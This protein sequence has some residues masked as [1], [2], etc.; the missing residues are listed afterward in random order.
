MFSR[1]QVSAGSFYLAVPRSA[2]GQGSVAR[3]AR[4]YFTGGDEG[5]VVCSNRRLQPPLRRD[6]GV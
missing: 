3:H 5:A 2:R 1:F 4:Q 6:G